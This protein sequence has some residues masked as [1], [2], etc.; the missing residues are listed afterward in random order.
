MRVKPNI[1]M[2][3]PRQIALRRE[4]AQ[5]ATATGS[6]PRQLE[7]LKEIERLG[8]NVLSGRQLAVF[9]ES[10]RLRIANPELTGAELADVPSPVFAKINQQTLRW[11]VRQVEKMPVGEHGAE[12]KDLLSDLKDA[13]AAKALSH[14]EMSDL[15]VRFASFAQKAEGK[16]L[17]LYDEN[18][19]KASLNTLQAHGIGA[20]FTQKPVA[21]RILGL[22]NAVP[23]PP[24]QVV[25]KSAWADELLMPPLDFSG[26]DGGHGIQTRSSWV[27][28]RTEDPVKNLERVRNA[29]RLASEMRAEIRSVS[30]ARLRSTIYRALYEEFHENGPIPIEVSPPQIHRKMLDRL[31]N[32]L[33]KG[34][35]PDDAGDAAIGWQSQYHAVGSTPREKAG[36]AVEALGWLIGSME[37]RAPA[38]TAERDR[39]TQDY[40]ATALKY[41]HFE[42]EAL[43]AQRA[44]G[45]IP[46]PTNP[47]EWI[48]ANAQVAGAA[49]RIAVEARAH[50]RKLS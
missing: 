4:K 34:G 28:T 20:W 24:V 32:T 40:V 12:A 35:N 15:T 11:Y 48:R 47:D 1:R 27:A 16:P 19:V 49:N 37:K 43:E 25:A 33:R 42:R 8:R 6:V 50:L 9:V 39:V 44:I 23:V 2:G 46:N 13:L 41:A 5:G 14:T 7:L 18:R 26:H 17:R 31:L 45:N 38:L 29:V 22:S 3:K 30:D 36:L 21:L 10:E